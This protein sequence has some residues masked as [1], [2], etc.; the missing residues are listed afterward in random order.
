VNTEKIIGFTV[1]ELGLSSMVLVAVK[2]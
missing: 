1:V 2:K